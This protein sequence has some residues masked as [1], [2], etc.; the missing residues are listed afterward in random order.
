MFVCW[1]FSTWGSGTQKAILALAMVTD[2]PPEVVA[3]TGLAA[4][5]LLSGCGWMKYL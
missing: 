1:I 2:I 3:F 5:A 4:A